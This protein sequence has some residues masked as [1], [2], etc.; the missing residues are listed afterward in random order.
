MV[1][2]RNEQDARGNLGE[3]AGISAYEEGNF[4]SPGL[5]HAHRPM[6]VAVRPVGMMQV[7]V[8]E[9]VNMVPVRNGGMAAVRTMHVRGRMSAALVTRRAGAW[10]GAAY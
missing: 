5:F 8:Y 4:A 7:A 3:S 9:I 10:I 1:S 6:V 2:G